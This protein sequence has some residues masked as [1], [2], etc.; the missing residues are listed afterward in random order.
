MRVTET[1]LPGVLLLQPKV[2]RDDRGFFLE[3]Y[4]QTFWS[5]LGIHEAFVQDNHSYSLHNVIRGIH[6]QIRHPQGK[7][8]RVVQGEILD[9]AVDLRKSSPTFGQWC[10]ATLSGENLSMLWIPAGFGHAFRVVSD[11]AHVLYKATDFYHPECERSIVWND[12]EI[13]ID[14]KLDAPPVVSSKDALGKS[15]EEAD[16]F[17]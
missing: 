12:P 2:F 10:A 1:S 15:L 3:S 11:S 17:D 7:L 8:V 4:N 14:W 9:I 6:Y 13:G 5:G 16:K